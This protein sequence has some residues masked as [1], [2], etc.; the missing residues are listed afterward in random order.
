MLGPLAKPTL[1]ILN[2]PTHGCPQALKAAAP[3]KNTDGLV[4]L[5]ILPRSH[6]GG[7]ILEKNMNIY[8]MVTVK[9]TSNRTTKNPWACNKIY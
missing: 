8:L 5:Q 7:I 4:C 9:F 6:A 2:L 3:C 1:Y